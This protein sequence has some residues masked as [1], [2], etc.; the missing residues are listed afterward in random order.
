VHSARGGVADAHSATIVGPR[1]A[2]ATS[3]ARGHYTAS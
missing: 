2:G 1:N 3:T